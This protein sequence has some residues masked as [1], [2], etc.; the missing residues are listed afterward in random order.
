V[1]ADGQIIVLRLVFG[2]HQDVPILLLRIKTIIS[3]LFPKN[4]SA[5]LIQLV[6]IVSTPALRVQLFC[7]LLITKLRVVYLYAPIA[8]IIMEIM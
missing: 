7:I 5:L 6:V 4:V 1:L 2:I 8:L 3:A